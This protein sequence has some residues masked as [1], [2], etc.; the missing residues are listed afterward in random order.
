MPDENLTVI[1]RNY[2]FWNAVAIEVTENRVGLENHGSAARAELNKMR[3]RR[4]ILEA[5]LRPDS[6]SVLVA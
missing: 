2:N 3:E 6:L 1:C 5:M 4:M